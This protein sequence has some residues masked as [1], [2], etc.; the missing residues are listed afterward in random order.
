MRREE[1]GRKEKVQVV[2]VRER[3]RHI[4]SKQ[5]CTIIRRIVL[6]LL[7]LLLMPTAVVTA[8]HV[9]GSYKGFAVIHLTF[10]FS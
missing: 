7:V 4:R 5:C 3:E 2:M 10:Y 8:V 9:T 6:S 1:K